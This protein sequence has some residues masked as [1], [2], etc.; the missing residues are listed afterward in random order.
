MRSLTHIGPPIGKCRPEVDPMAVIVRPV[1]NGD[2]VEMQA[3]QCQV[4][5]LVR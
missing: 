3:M 2:I 4:L 1:A 5:L